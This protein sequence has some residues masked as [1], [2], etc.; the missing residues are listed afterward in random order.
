MGLGGSGDDGEAEAQA[1]ADRKARIAKEQQQLKQAEEKRTR[2][3]RARMT[4]GALVGSG[5]QNKDTLG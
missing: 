4:G 2:F 3:M 1:R 5:D